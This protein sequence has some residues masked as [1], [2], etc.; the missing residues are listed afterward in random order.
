M[1][2]DQ[3]DLNTVKEPNKF[4]SQNICGKH[5]KLSKEVLL[6]AINSCNNEPKVSVRA[7]INFF[8][9]HRATLRVG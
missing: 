6:D 5:V 3:K 1:P 7:A 2:N 9:I 8:R 4:Q